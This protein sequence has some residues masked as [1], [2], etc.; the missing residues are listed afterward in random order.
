MTHDIVDYRSSAPACGAAFRR[1]RPGPETDLV[2]QFLENLRLPMLRGYRATIFCE[3]R[4]ASGFPDLVVVIWNVAATRRWNPQRAGLLREDI[5]LL[6]Y[7][8]LHGRHFATHEMLKSVFQRG[9]SASLDRLQVAGLV[10]H[11][12]QRYV[13]RP[14]SHAFAV[15]RIIAIEAKVSEWSA[16]LDQAFLNTWFTSESYVLLPRRKATKRLRGIAKSRG[17]RICCPGD[18]IISKTVSI[19]RARPRSYVSWLFNEWAWR[20]AEGNGELAV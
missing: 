6:H 5:R 16:A 18:V 7:L 13:P 9:L 17:I 1:Q 11:K 12:S 8:Y 15:H 10:S 4:I 2:K 20:F 14:L 3:P 19:P